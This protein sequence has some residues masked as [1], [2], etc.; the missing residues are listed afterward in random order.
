MLANPKWAASLRAIA[1]AC[2]AI[3]LTGTL[4]AGA[5]DASAQAQP[6]AGETTQTAAAGELHTLNIVG[7]EGA[8][9]LPVW[10]AQQEGFFAAHGLKVD[11]DFPSS[12]VEVIRHLTDNSAQMALMGID[13]VLAYR[14]AQGEKGAPNADDLVAFMG[15]DHGYLTLVARPG[16]HTVDELRGHTVS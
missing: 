15:G 4:A 16:I 7:F 3:A 14:R 2:A 9:N 13:N 11:L 12:S 5:A 8:F 1:R 10:V 6:A